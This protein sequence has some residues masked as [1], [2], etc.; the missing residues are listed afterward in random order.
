M[1]IGPRAKPNTNSVLRSG[2]QLESHHSRT[3][4]LLRTESEGYCSSV[5][6]HD[7]SNEVKTVNCYSPN[8]RALA[9]EPSSITDE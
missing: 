2:I 3:S 4:P 5:Y 9:E 1:F 7:T 8:V 6:K